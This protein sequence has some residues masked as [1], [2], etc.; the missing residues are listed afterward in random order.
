MLTSPPAF[1][2]LKGK[3]LPS[4][5]PKGYIGRSR[6]GK[7]DYQPTHIAETIALREAAR[8]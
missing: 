8:H 5:I 3:A 1:S 6:F 4:A 7:H 2:L